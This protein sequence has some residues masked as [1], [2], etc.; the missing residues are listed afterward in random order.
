M[1]P[2]LAH[3]FPAVSNAQVRNEAHACLPAH[4]WAICL[5][6]K[7]RMCLLFPPHHSC[8][9]LVAVLA[10]LPAPPSLTWGWG[11]GG[12]RKKKKEMYVVDEP[13]CP[14]CP[15]WASNH[16]QFDLPSE[17]Y[18]PWVYWNSSYISVWK[19]ELMVFYKSLLWLLDFLLLWGNGGKIRNAE[20]DRSQ[21]FPYLVLLCTESDKSVP[22]CFTW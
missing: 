1:L 3:T 2:P 19:I 4:L 21:V 16:P 11:V 15:G 18:R 8:L 6:S 5:V 17:R 12:G 9:Q 14:R 13:N 22:V 10:Q 20:W 7:S